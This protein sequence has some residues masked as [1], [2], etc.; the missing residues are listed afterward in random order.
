MN[1]TEMRAAAERIRVSTHPAA[2]EIADL[3]ADAA[4]ELSHHE[5]VWDQCGELW[6]PTAKTD[7]TRWLYPRHIALAQ[8][9]TQTQ[10][11]L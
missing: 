6:L 4:T 9:L 7:I 10:V 3:L 5:T 11:I 1:S 2:E 8:K